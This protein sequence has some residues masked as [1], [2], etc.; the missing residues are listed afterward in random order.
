M[1]QRTIVEPQGRQSLA[2]DLGQLRLASVCYCM[3]RSGRTTASGADHRGWPE[4]RYESRSP[5]AVRPLQSLSLLTT[6]QQ[7]RARRHSG[8]LAK[9]ETPSEAERRR[10]TTDSGQEGRRLGSLA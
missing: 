10:S 1:G 9:Q 8:E 7:T 6:P 4:R 3:S 2:Q 5:C